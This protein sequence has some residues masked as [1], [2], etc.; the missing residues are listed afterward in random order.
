MFLHRCGC[1]DQRL[2]G[3]QHAAVALISSDRNQRH[4][5]KLLLGDVWGWVTAEN[6]RNRIIILEEIQSRTEP[7]AVMWQLC[8]RILHKLWP[9]LWGSRWSSPR[10]PLHR[11]STKIW[12]ARDTT[13]SN[14]QSENYSFWWNLNSSG[15]TGL[16]SSYKYQYL[17]LMFVW[18]HCE[19][20]PAGARSHRIS[21][22]I[23]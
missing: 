23:S 18:H 20:P 7:L 15:T 6:W 1:T 4:G 14:S 16:S 2:I 19:A 10:G 13:T 17:Q 5:A 21:E 8:D 22:R 12:D 3:W 11:C 9:E